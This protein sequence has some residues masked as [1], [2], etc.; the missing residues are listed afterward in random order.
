MRFFN[1]DGS[2]KFPFRAKSLTSHGLREFVSEVDAL[3]KTG[4]KF[5]DAR[6]WKTKKE[7]GRDTMATQSP[8]ADSGTTGPTLY[9]MVAPGKFAPVREEAAK[10]NFAK[11]LSREKTTVAVAAL[12]F[13]LA[14]LFP[15]WLYTEDHTNSNSRYGPPGRHLQFNAG[16]HC[17]FSAPQRTGEFGGVKLDIERLLI[18]WA[19]IGVA[20][21]A[22]W[23]VC[24]TL[25]N[26]DG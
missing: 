13:V 22:V 12:A 1:S 24:K 15:P 17:I 8:K 26:G 18:E 7:K 10:A 3:R 19:C 23:F 11:F 14:G 9:R 5:L 2:K 16:Y 6:P 25:P 20:T 4:V 21:G